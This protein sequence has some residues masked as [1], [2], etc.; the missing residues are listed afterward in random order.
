MFHGRLLSRTVTQTGCQSCIYTLFAPVL[1]K[2]FAVLVM[3]VARR[4]GVVRTET[5]L[6][7]NTPRNGRSDL[8]I[9]IEIIGWTAAVMMLSAYL[10]LTSGRLS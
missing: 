9:L 7:Q 3:C 8:K 4:W 1:T 6:G 2:V 10:L 5:V